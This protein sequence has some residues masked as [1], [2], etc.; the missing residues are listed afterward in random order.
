VAT[1]NGI[2]FSLSL[3]PGSLL[4]LTEGVV[5]GFAILPGLLSNKNIRIPTK[6]KTLKSCPRVPKLKI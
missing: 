2:F 6:K 5:V 1:I 4:I 3:S